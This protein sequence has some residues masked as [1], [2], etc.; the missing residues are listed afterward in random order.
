MS[1]LLA[2]SRH[3]GSDDPCPLQDSL[4]EI[5]QV[6]PPIAICTLLAQA[7]YPLQS[8]QNPQTPLERQQEISVPAIVLHWRDVLQQ[9]PD[10]RSIATIHVRL[11]KQ[12]RYA[13][14]QDHHRNDV[15]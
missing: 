2:Q 7:R 8:Y 9:L 15:L 4:K 11:S 6:R 13:T 3:P 10:L 5:S 12:A 1:P 14:Q